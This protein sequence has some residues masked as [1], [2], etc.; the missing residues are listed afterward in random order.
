MEVINNME[1][2]EYLLVNRLKEM[3]CVITTVESCTGGL[4]ASR[5][6][7]VSGASGISKEGFITYCD[8]AKV[9]MVGVPAKVIDEY[10]AVSGETAEAM[11]KGGMSTAHADGCISVT[12]VAGPD[13]E[14]GKPVGLVYVGCSFKDKTVSFQFNFKGDRQSI[15]NQACQKALE[16]MYDLIE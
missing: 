8:E 1:D 3:D 14:D 11:A 5:I 10:K 7:N 9:S 12:G 2:I 15:R 13:M 16:C 6:V 4:I